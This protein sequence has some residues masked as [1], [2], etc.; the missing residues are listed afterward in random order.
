MIRTALQLSH[1]RGMTEREL[2]RFEVRGRLSDRAALELAPLRVEDVDVMTVLTGYLDEADAHGVIDR[3][4]RFGL[5][6]V[7]LQRV[8]DTGVMSK[9]SGTSD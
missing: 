2:Y 1:D 4:R 7:S 8:G 9:S 6:L 5:E 3:I